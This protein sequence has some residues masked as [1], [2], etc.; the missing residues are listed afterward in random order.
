MKIQLARIQDIPTDKPLGVT[1]EG[2]PLVLVRLNDRIKLYDGE[3]PHQKALLE[4]GSVE[5]GQLVCYM[6]EWRFD[7]V[8]GQKEGKPNACLHALTPI[9]EGDRVFVDQEEVFAYREKL[10]M[11][12]N[13]PTTVKELPGPPGKPIVGNI[14]QLN[15]AELHRQLEAWADEYG[16]MYKIRMGPSGDFVVLAD[17]DDI[18]TVF[19]ERPHN[20][21]RIKKLE[22]IFTE[23]GALSVFN[24]EGDDWLRHRKLTA[25]GLNA[26]VIREFYPNIQQIAERLHCRW[27]TAVA[28]NKPLPIM[29]ELMRFTV[30]VTTFMAMGYDMNTLENEENTIQEQLHLIFPAYY[31][32]VNTPIPYWR[33][34]KLPVDRKLDKAFKIVFEHI[35][36]LVAKARERMEAHP[37]LHKKPTN[38]V[39]GLLADKG[40]G[41]KVT[42]EE[43]KGNILTLLVAGE[44]TTAHTLS[45][46]MYFLSQHPEAQAK[47]QAEVDQVLGDRFVPTFEE[48]QGFPYMEAIIMEVFRLKPVAPLLY[49]GTVQETKL[50]GV[51]LPEDTSII[52]VNHYSGQ[53]ET[54]FDEAKQFQ[55][56]RWLEGGTA[57]KHQE[58]IVTPFG[59]GP[60]F[61]P[62]RGLAFVELKVVLALIAKNYHVSLH[63]DPATVKEILAFS[64]MPSSFHVN[65]NPRVAEAV[66]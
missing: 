4:E 46:V 7:I 12:T 19:Q 22:R 30:D 51:T 3:C 1:V 16:T 56:E 58:S 20:Y 66:S 38:Y 62:G 14:P 36:A 27:Q 59:G 6:H 10:G 26:M 35:D 24:T 50:R 54:H 48:T 11:E 49:M 8:S 39:E 33:F 44:E 53:Q 28:A 25:K 43:L 18:Q 63:E 41:M 21:R 5:N 31:R 32:R 65:F 13:R 2:L 45:W 9:F 61:C 47:L 15:F 42:E 64:M 23:T 29:D 34:F 55:P 60:R 37:E 17:A 52:L 40:D 57:G